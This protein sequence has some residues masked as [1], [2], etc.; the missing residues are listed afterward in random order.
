MKK[1]VI[2]VIV[3]LV[4]I[5]VVAAVGFGRKLLDKYSYSKEQADLDAYFE[6]AEGELAIILQDEMI[7][8]KAVLK[9]DVVYFDLDTVHACFN[10]GFYADINEQKLLYTTAEDTAAR[11]TVW[12]R[13]I[14][15][16][17]R[18]SC[19]SIYSLLCRG[20]KSVCGSGLCEA[21]HKLF[22]YKI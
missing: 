7:P 10:E 4:L 6:V 13:G 18:G 16:Q 15:R 8:Q 14:L 17:G 20:G 19:H 3:A 2:P 12:G 22:L 1:K 11:R 21:V 9:G 5:A